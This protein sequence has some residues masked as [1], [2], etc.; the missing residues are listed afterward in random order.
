MEL[1]L[2]FPWMRSWCGK[3]QLCLNGQSVPSTSRAEFILNVV[4][5]AMVFCMWRFLFMKLGAV[6]VRVCVR[7]CGGGGGRGCGGVD[8]E[9]TCWLGWV[10]VYKGYP[11]TKTQPPPASLYTNHTRRP[12]NY[13]SQREGKKRDGK[14]KK[15]GPKPLV[16]LC[17]LWWSQSQ[18]SKCIREAKNKNKKWKSSVTWL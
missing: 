9:Q 18:T 8:L 14:L 2:F 17:A 10:W 3:W 5:F 15:S 4:R 11:A 13:K 6:Y 1:Y 12:S 16:S 7:V